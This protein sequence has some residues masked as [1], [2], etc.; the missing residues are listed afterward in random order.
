M[1]CAICG[2]PISI[3][4]FDLGNA[5]EAIN[6]ITFRMA[7]MHYDCFEDALETAKE[8][9]SKHP[10]YQNRYDEYITKNS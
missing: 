8:T 1:K 6:P 9:E 5:F 7:K 10:E 4:E 2:L 3:H